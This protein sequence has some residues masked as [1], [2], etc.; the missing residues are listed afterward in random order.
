MASRAV[1]GGQGTG[2]MTRAP[3]TAFWG[4]GT[5]Q[6]GRQLGRKAK[7]IWR[8]W[9]SCL[10]SYWHTLQMELLLEPC[11]AWLAPPGS[12]PYSE[13]LNPA[14]KIS[15]VSLHTLWSLLHSHFLLHQLMLPYPSVSGGVT[16]QKSLFLDPP[17]KSTRDPCNVYVQPTTSPL[18]H[19]A[20]VFPQSRKSLR[21]G[22][23]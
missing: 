5:S 7:P 21:V 1:Q 20:P 22:R 8:S 23:L 14:E 16:F 18:Q 11:V 12:S 4:P 10:T 19:Q 2:W 3:C 15:L 6:R 9:G 13:P 17:T